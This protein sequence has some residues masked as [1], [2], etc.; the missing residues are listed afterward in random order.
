MKL[1][2]L[3]LI[4]SR[5]SFTQSSLLAPLPPRPKSL[6]FSRKD[7][8]A[9]RRYGQLVC[10][11]IGG[12]YI[13]MKLLD[14]F[15]GSFKT[16]V[17]N[18]E[19]K[20]IRTVEE[21]NASDVV[22]DN[23]CLVVTSKSGSTP[24]VK[25]LY[26]LLH[27]SVDY[28]VQGKI[29]DE[30]GFEIPDDVGGRFSIYA[31]LLPIAVKYG[32]DVAEE[33]LNCSISSL[34]D[35]NRKVAAALANMDLRTISGGSTGKCILVYDT[36]LTPVVEYVQQL[37]M[38]SLG[39]PAKSNT[40]NIV[41]GGYGPGLQHSIMQLVHQGSA[42]IPCEFLVVRRIFGNNAM[43]ANAE[44][45]SLALRE[46]GVDSLIWALEPSVLSLVNYLTI[47]ELRTLHYATLME[48]NPFDQP[49]VE[50]GKRI[51]VELM[52]NKSKSELLSML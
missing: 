25:D 21:C 46:V 18:G 16:P 3:T 26:D 45:Q 6:P 36:P 15:L 43:W 41:F 38:E 33:I 52:E 20:F 49:G 4:H 50:L 23:T 19:I 39:K 28:V 8:E 35:E 14:S 48:I 44:A 1:N 5:A 30:V 31:T 42:N 2:D 13:G 32:Y 24:E 47:Q 10:I 9:L 7:V 51:A 29:Y 22:F 17:W 12:S 37:E 11:G 27:A 40:G 34:T